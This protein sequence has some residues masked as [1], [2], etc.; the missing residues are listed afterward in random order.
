M[1]RAKRIIPFV[2]AIAIVLA[3]GSGIYLKVR[4][5][6]GGEAA[7]GGGE[8]GAATPPEAASAFATDV[9]NP[10]QGAEVVR[11]TLVLY[12]TGGGQA[13]ADRQAVMLAQ[14]AGRVLAA[15]V[16][17]NDA[18]GEGAVRVVSDPTE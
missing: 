9:A 4:G 18:V 17:E 8:P 7:P 15:G 11:D 5:G 2:V 12:R 1:I 6:E 10:V 3:L 14:V 13:A 16:R